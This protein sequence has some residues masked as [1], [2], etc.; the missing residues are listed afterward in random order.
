MKPFS[1]ISGQKTHSKGGM[2]NMK[3]SETWKCP[4]CGE[5]MHRL[6]IRNNTIWKCTNIVMCTGCESMINKSKRVTK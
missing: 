6:Y 2:M 3:E 5:R 1:F 4:V